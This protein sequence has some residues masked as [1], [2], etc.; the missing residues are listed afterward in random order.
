MLNERRHS[1]RDQPLTWPI[2][3]SAPPPGVSYIRPCPSLT[4]D[5]VLALVG[6]GGLLGTLGLAVLDE[7][8]LLLR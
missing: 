8:S 4:L 7:V 3:V 2:Q 5:C 1:F 6:E